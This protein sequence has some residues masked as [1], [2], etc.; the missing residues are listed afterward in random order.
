MTNVFGG[1]GKKGK[2]GDI[3]Y[4]LVAKRSQLATKVTRPTNAVENNIV[5]IS[6]Y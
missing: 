6:S 2:S 1:Y 5:T 4:S 3:D